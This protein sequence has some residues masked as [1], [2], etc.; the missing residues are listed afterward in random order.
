MPAGFTSEDQARELAAA[1]PKPKV[2]RPITFADKEIAT[3]IYRQIGPIVAGNMDAKARNTF[4]VTNGVRMTSCRAGARKRVDV[5]V[6]LNSGDLY[7]IEVVSS[8][9][10]KADSKPI[11][12]AG[13]VHV[14]QLQGMMLKIGDGR[15]EEIAA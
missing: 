7:D 9:T 4:A 14:S 12:K 8:P 3:T 11:A 1:N 6:T 5:T 10:L 13:N 15:P 2:Q